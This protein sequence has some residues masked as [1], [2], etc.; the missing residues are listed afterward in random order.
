MKHS[1]G[2]EELVNKARHHIKE[3]SIQAVKTLMDNN[4]LPLFLDVREDNE[5]SID[6]LPHAKHLGRGIIERD[7]EIMVPDKNRQIILYCSGGFRSILATESLQ[8]IGYHQVKS[9]QGGYREW[10]AAGYPITKNDN[11]ACA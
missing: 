6:H 3:I 5:W 11:K 10:K 2:F 8:K 1:M 9:M 4:Q 7:I